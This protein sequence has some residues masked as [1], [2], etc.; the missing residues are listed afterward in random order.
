MTACIDANT[1]LCCGFFLSWEGGTYSLRNLMLNV[2]ANKVE[3]CGSHNVPIRKD[4]WD[5]SALPGMLISDKG[6]E[7][8]GETFSQLTDLGVV[9]VDLEAFRPDLK[10]MVEKFFDIIQ[11]YF[12]SELKGKG[13]VEK[14]FGERTNRIDYRK[15]AC[16]TLD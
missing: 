10:P 6:S 12:K 15:Q 2:I 4:E 8:V 13:V 7:Y 1:A 5:C 14:D 9:L 16:L 3:Y 11:G